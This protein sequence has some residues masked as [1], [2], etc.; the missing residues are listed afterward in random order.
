MKK[1][2]SFIYLLLI[3]LLTTGNLFASG[4]NRNGTAGATQLLIP[5]GARG[6]ALG[7]SAIVNA[8][9]L[10]ALYYNPANLSRASYATNAMFSHMNYIADIGVEYGAIS[11]S[12]EG[13]GTIAVSIKSLAINEIDIT[14]ESNPDG[15]GAT[16][17]PG[18]TTIGLTYS[19]MLSDRIAV[20]L[21]AN[22]IQEELD[23]VSAS[24]ISFDIGVSYSNLANI[25][26]LSMAIVMKN[27]GPQMKYDGSGL[28]LRAEAN[29]LTRPEQYYK[30]DAA[31]FE[32]PSTLELGLG[33][34]YDINEQNSLSF[35]GLFQNANFYGDE[36][37]VGAEYGYD[38]LLF[39]RAG[40][41]VMPE[42]E[43]DENGFGLTAGVGLNYTLGDAA[44][45]INYAYRQVEFF[46]DNHVF[47]VGLGF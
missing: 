29:S 26:G 45:Q 27:L 3:G 4:G 47:S 40:Y 39:I 8:S 44:L 18:F 46:E 20:G 38:N 5:V 34:Q 6:I 10:E 2:K 21:T 24:G 41:S 7:G 28:F 36:Y 30:I 37:R 14:T 9:G 1:I 17:K 12:I 15:T 19:K 13:L 25:Q 16:F 32:L 31:S 43:T 42:L 33:Y 22:L 23:L 11:T 35:N